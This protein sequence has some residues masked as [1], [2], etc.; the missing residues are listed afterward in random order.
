MFNLKVENEE[1][2]R[3]VLIEKGAEIIELNPKEF[4]N[5][6]ID[7]TSILGREE[8]V[9]EVRLRVY[10]IGETTPPSTEIGEMVYNKKVGKWSIV[11]DN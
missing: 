9:I 11:I 10:E 2:Y 7:A 8:R 1:M 4:L 5:V 6:L 3:V